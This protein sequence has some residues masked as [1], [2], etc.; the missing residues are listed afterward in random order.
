MQRP[1]DHEMPALKCSVRQHVPTVWPVGTLHYV[2]N[3]MCVCAL[4]VHGRLTWK[5]PSPTINLHLGAL[6]PH[7]PGSGESVT[8]KQTHLCDAGTQ[9]LQHEDRLSRVAHNL[10]RVEAQHIVVLGGVLGGLGPVPVLDEGALALQIL[11]AGKWS[12]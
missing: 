9:Q 1:D 8:T 3:T 5:P 10:A 12:R 2:C 4:F 7:G 11:R 6:V